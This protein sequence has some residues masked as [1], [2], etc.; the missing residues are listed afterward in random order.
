MYEKSGKGQDAE[1]LAAAKAVVDASRGQAAST[2]TMYSL[3]VGVLFAVIYGYSFFRALIQCANVNDAASVFG[4]TSIWAIV[5]TSVIV[6]VG[7]AYRVGSIRGPVI[8]TAPWLDWVVSSPVDRWLALRAYWSP[9]ALVGVGLGSAIGG[10]FGG[11]L[12]NI[13]DGGPWAMILGVIF[14][15]L[16]GWIMVFAW[17]C[18]QV[19]R[20]SRNVPA[21]IRR[22]RRET[23][24]RHSLAASGIGGGVLIGD[25]RVVRWVA[26]AP[27]RHGRNLR[28]SNLGRSWT[29]VVRDLLGLI[30]NPGGSIFG[31]V[32]IESGLTIMTLALL[33]GGLSLLTLSVGVLF[34]YAGAGKMSI[35]LRAFTDGIRLPAL[36]GISATRLTLLHCVTPLAVGCVAGVVTW[37]PWTLAAGSAPMAENAWAM[38]CIVVSVSAI[39]WDGSR[40]RVCIPTMPYQMLFEL[41]LPI[42]LTMVFVMTSSV[43]FTRD[44][45]VTWLEVALATTGA[46]L[47]LGF[48][49][50]RVGR[51]TLWR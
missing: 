41:A 20:G 28:L 15:S 45:Q 47:F 3:Y 16:A 25:A 36:S 50:N 5:I 14:G 51:R 39:V 7:L 12:W 37:F 40:A 17:L 34:A 18:G 22:L 21:A 42:V 27:I 35:G 43:L 19:G 29:V 1:C 11:G 31:L 48:A 10:A 8:P 4:D 9:I 23:L 13:A 26:T 49:A 30:R 44:G 24:R 38:V 33:G 32:L 2:D 46:V 6:L